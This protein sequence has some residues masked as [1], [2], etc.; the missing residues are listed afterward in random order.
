VRVA[1][2][3]RPVVVGSVGLAL[4][5]VGGCAH[6]VRVD[7]NVPD[8]VVRVD[9]E[10]VGTVREGATFAEHWGFGTT[11]D[12]DV[13]APGHRIERR[14]LRPSIV[15]P[16][17]AVPAIVGGVGGCVAGGCLMPLAALSSS[18]AS[19]F[20]AWSGLS[21]LTLAAA[22]GACAVGFA[23]SDRL[24]DVITVNLERE[25]GAGSDGD[26]PPPP[27]DVGEPAPQPPA[28]APA[29]AAPVGSTSPA[30]A[31]SDAGAATLRW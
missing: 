31:T 27:V 18:D 16:A 6:R 28:S 14:L 26:L 1:R 3:L 7:S 8:A 10:K 29:P 19:G 22:G 11:Y 2:F 24:P 20:T 17:V 13:A 15:E 21:A 5:L 4:A 25:V 9:G 30:D 12:I 23:A